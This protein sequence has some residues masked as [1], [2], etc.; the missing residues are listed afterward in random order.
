ME[1]TSADLEMHLFKNSSQNFKRKIQHFAETSKEEK[2]YCRRTMPSITLLI[3]ML[4]CD[5]FFFFCI[6]PSI[7]SCT[8][9]IPTGT[10]EFTPLHDSDSEASIHLNYTLQ[11][12]MST[13]YHIICIITK[14]YGNGVRL[15]E[16]LIKNGE[17]GSQLVPEGRRKADGNKSNDNDGLLKRR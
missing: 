16:G 12:R 2:R 9:E 10:V 7:I 1:T 4:L 15:P 14:Y 13:T 8:Q 5:S 17:R 11:E 3:Y 6:H